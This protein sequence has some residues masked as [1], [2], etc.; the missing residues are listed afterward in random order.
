MN[1]CPSCG[2]RIT[3]ELRLGGWIHCDGPIPGSVWCTDD[4]RDG[5]CALGPVMGR[6]P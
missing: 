1:L 2:Y 5:S 4:P 6:K 3:Y